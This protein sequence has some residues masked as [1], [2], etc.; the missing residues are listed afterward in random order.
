MKWKYWFAQKIS[1]VKY[2]FGEISVI[3]RQPQ[4]FVAV[5]GPARGASKKGNL[6]QISFCAHTNGI[7]QKGAIATRTVANKEDKKLAASVTH[8]RLSSA[9]G[10]LIVIDTAAV[11]EL[12]VFFLLLT[13]ISVHPPST[14]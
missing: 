12:I 5:Q 4:D 2:P 7:F 6:N 9:C 13:E 14:L 8:A 1:F 3:W 11:V 10:N